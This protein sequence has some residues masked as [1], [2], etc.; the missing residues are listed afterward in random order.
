MNVYK[1]KISNFTYAT[2]TGASAIQAEN[3]L[4][5]NNAIA[6]YNDQCST[7]S[8]TPQLKN[9]TIINSTTIHAACPTISLNVFNSIVLVS[10]TNQNTYT[11][12]PNFNKVI[13]NDVN[14]VPQENS[15][16][17]V[18]LDGETDIYF[19]DYT[20]GDYTLSEFS[21]AIGF[22]S[23]PVTEDILG[24]PRPMP[25]GSSLDAG[26]FESSLGSPS[27][28]A[29]RFGDIADISTNED[30]GLHSINII[31]IVD[32]DILSTQDLTFTV[33]SDN[34]SLFSLLE[35]SYMQGEN[36]AVLNYDTNLNQNG[37]A[38]ISVTLSDDGNGDPNIVNFVNKGFEISVFPV[39][40]S[41]TDIFLSNQLLTEN[42]INIPVALL[43]AEDID[44]DAFSYE[45]VP[46]VGDQNNSSFEIVGTDLRVVSPFDF[47]NTPEAFVRLRVLDSEELTFE[48]EFVITIQD[49]NDSPV[50]NDQSITL[51]EDTLA[52]VS[53]TANDQDNDPL[54]YTIVNQPTNGTAVLTANTI[55]YTPIG[56]YSGLDSF[57]FT[58]NDGT[59]DSNLATVSID[60]LPVN[61]APTS[62]E[63]TSSSIVENIIASVGLISCVDPDADDVYAYELV[64][65]S[66]DTNNN[67]FEIIG[68]ELYNI[69]PLNFETQELYTVRIKASNVNDEI[70]EVFPI[71]VTNVNDIN[72]A[73]QIQDSYCEGSTGDG[74]ITITEINEVSG[75]VVFDWT[76]PNGFTSQDQSII[77]LEPGLYDLEVSDDFFTYGE[78]FSV[79]L[80][81]I[82][83]NLEICYV[84][85][86]SN[87]PTK[88]RIYLNKEGNYNV[89][90]YKVF[91]ET[92][93]ADQYQQIGLVLPTEDSF[94]DNNSNNL[95]RQYKY[96][97]ATLDNCGVESGFSEVHYN[98]F[99]QANLSS[100]GNVNLFWEPYFGLNYDS[101]YIY[102]SENGSTFEILAVLP[103]N[104]TVYNDISADVGSNDYSY[105]IGIIAEECTLP[106]PFNGGA[107]TRTLPIIVQSNPLVIVDGS[108]GVTQMIYTGEISLYPNPASDQINIVCPE[109]LEFIKVELYNINGQYLGSNNFKNMSVSQLQGGVYFLKIYTKQGAFIKKIIKK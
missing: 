36:N 6:I 30:S 82:Y 109:Q 27:N 74:Q 50:A 73:S 97:V 24:N 90:A 26:A 5:I 19:T 1:S 42:T 31:E 2:S 34:P 32:G 61:D 93:I 63:I 41:P 71:Q 94:L 44:D 106:D 38:N 55:D 8:I 18:A 72:I 56:D 88:N 40:D 86:D 14:V 59:I 10:D 20:G 83:E 69:N 103:S 17:E 95:I 96:K 87:E 79:G 7:G 75:N 100:G 23:F 29:P 105:Y 52:S 22:G 108:L 68:N 15:T 4:L 35:I 54:T 25:I 45:L 107:D 37:T 85:G 12:A 99:L 58:V 33:S 3:C 64:V 60:V 101:F 57:T 67:L 104:Q 92:T 70:E 11:S 66:G 53:L 13:T 9:C 28:A 102:R 91:R 49:I 81:P 21:P 39:N 62:I 47:E 43:T 48:K 84:S 76:G 51:D 78:S 16:W 80:I 46:G 77:N 65:G 89:G 98:T